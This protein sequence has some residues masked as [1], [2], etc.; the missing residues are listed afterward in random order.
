VRGNHKSLSWSY[1][2][3]IDRQGLPTADLA[4]QLSGLAVVLGLRK[5]QPSSLHT[6]GLV[7]IPWF[8]ETIS[9]DTRDSLRD[10][11]DLPPAAESFLPGFIMDAKY[12]SFP[13]PP[14][15]IRPA[16]P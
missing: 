3:L 16:L 4:S 7:H 9:R 5:F 2:S 10:L 14:C 1:Y 15:V 13:F 8:E 6:A 12:S 11:P